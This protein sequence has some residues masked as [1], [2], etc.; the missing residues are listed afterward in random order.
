MKKGHSSGHRRNDN[1]GVIK[2]QKGRNLEDLLFFSRSTISMNDIHG[3]EKRRTL[4][5][6]P[7]PPLFTLTP[8]ESWE[9]RHA[10][11]GRIDIKRNTD[12]EKFDFHKQKTSKSRGKAQTKSEFDPTLYLE[13]PMQIPSS[14]KLTI[15]LSLL[16]DYYQRDITHH[17][18]V[19]FLRYKY[20]RSIDQYINTSLRYLLTRSKLQKKGPNLQQAHDQRHTIK[21]K[22][23][24]SDCKFD[25]SWEEV[26][27]ANWRKYCP[28]NH[29]STHVIAVDTLSRH[30]DADTGI[31]CAFP[32]PLFYFSTH[33]TQILIQYSY[34]PN[35]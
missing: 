12:G 20:N 8:L 24:S 18:F 32:F 26:S 33:N 34:A 28:W 23:F 25:Y 19:L 22:V 4:P 13:N 3:E 15:W 5:P 30:V 29:K 10:R 31:V 35:V 2:V 27:T 6:P 14:Y 7:P 17:P 21:M 1:Q 16:L 11:H 9:S